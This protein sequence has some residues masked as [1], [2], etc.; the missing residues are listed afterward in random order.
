MP[1]QLTDQ[2]ATTLERVLQT[3]ESEG[4][5]LGGPIGRMLVRGAQDWRTTLSPMGCSATRPHSSPTGAP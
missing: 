2:E 4:E 1:R 5:Q 3:M